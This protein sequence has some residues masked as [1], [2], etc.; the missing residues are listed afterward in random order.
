RGAT[1]LGILLLIVTWTPLVAWW[2]SWLQ[3]PWTDA[4][5]DLLII[6]S[7]SLEG[8]GILGESS[9]WR[10]FYAVLA[11]REGGWRQIL[12]TGGGPAPTAE[13]IRLFLQAGGVP[14]ET[15]RIDTKSRTTRE[16]AVNVKAALEN[17]T[18]SKVLLTSDYHM[19]RAR[20]AFR[21]AGLAV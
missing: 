18:G 2:A 16:S 10:S 9:Y 7:G 12:I 3:G 4:R 14:V 20:R 8:A 15:I 6:P 11:W 19:F 1:V 21:R 13:V 5:G 17:E